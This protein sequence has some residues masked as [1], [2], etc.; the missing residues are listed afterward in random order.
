L[1]IIRRRIHVTRLL[2]VIILLLRRLLRR[3]NRLAGRIERRLRKGRS[4]K[5]AQKERGRAGTP[6]CCT[7]YA[8]F[9]P[10]AVP[11]S[12]DEYA[13]KPRLFG[14]QIAAARYWYIVHQVRVDFVSIGGRF[15]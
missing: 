12:Y 15:G 1:L 4:G 13:C 5:R 3:I 14:K 10:S 6:H 11:R 2:H 8:G 7:R 9:T